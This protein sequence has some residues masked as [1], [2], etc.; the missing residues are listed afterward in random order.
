M[1]LVYLYFLY[2]SFHSPWFLTIT[3]ICF[4]LFFFVFLFC[5]LCLV[6][7]GRG[8]GIGGWGRWIRENVQFTKMW[9]FTIYGNIATHI[10]FILYF[11]DMCGFS[12]M[13]SCKR[14]GVVF[15]LIKQFIFRR[16]KKKLN[17]KCHLSFRLIPVPF[18]RYEKIIFYSSWSQVI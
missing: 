10:Q 15:F 12:H 16:E 9:L 13:H 1:C 4:F 6:V 17:R 18:E 14:T 3:L 7:E 8:W 11:K 2:H 5:F